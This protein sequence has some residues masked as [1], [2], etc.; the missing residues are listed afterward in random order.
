MDDSTPIIV[1]ILVLLLLFMGGCITSCYSDM[2]DPTIKVQCASTATDKEG[3]MKE[4]VAKGFAS[5]TNDI[6]GQPLWS[7]NI[8]YIITN[9]ITAT[10]F[11]VETNTVTITNSVQLEKGE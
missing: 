4:A 7:W 2:N 10:N 3:F 11:I 1:I 6:N 5:Y 8:V 9:Y